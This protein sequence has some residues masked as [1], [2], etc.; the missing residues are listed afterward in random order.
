MYF[1]LLLKVFLWLVK[2]FIWVL[3]GWIFVCCVIIFVV[4]EYVKSGVIDVVSMSDDNFIWIIF[5]C[6]L[7]IEVFD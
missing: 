1:C 2:K 3:L 7:F 6:D 4:D 5:F